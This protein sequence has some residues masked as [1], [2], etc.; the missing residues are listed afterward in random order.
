MSYSVCCERACF[1]RDG[2]N[3]ARRSLTPVASK[4]ALAIAAGTGRVA[5]SPAPVGDRS[6]LLINAMSIGASLTS[7]IGYE[8]QSM[9]VTLSLSKVTSSCRARLVLCMMLPSMVSFRLS[10]FIISPQS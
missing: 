3:G 10:G 7:S 8:I 4:R 2:V 6:G 5:A 9:L 1:T